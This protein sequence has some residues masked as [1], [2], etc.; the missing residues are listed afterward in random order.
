MSIWHDMMRDELQPQALTWFQY[1][2]GLDAFAFENVAF[3]FAF[4]AFAF[5]KSLAQRGHLYLNTF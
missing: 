4:N 3:I 1:Q 5:L 2:L